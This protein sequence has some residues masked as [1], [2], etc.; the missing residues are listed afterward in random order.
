[1]RKAKFNESQIVDS[2]AG[3]RSR[4]GSH[5]ICLR[6]HGVSRATFCKWRSQYGGARVITMSRTVVQHT[7]TCG[8]RIPNS[9]AKSRPGTPL[10]WRLQ[11]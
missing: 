11:F 5:T 7:R 8:S 10:Q 6:K 4:R 9:V 2:P 3:R 1:M